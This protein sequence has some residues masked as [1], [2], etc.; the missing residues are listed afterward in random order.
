MFHIVIIV[1]C[2]LV[3]GPQADYSKCE[4]IARTFYAP[5]MKSQR[6]TVEQ[7][8]IL[9]PAFVKILVDLIFK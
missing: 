8:S 7:M 6:Y 1:V 3:Q 9:E 4:N 2:A 5:V